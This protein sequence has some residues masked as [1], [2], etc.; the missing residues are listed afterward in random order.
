MCSVAVDP[1]RLTL[2]P[3]NAGA[4]FELAVFGGF[5]LHQSG[6][7]VDLPTRKLACLLTYL[8]CSGPTSQ[9][10]EKLATLLWGDSSEERARHNLRQAIAKLRQILGPGAILNEHD[11]LR[12]AAGTLSC[13][14]VAFDDLIRDGSPAALAEAVDLFKGGFLE[15]IVVREEAWNDWL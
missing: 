14:A 10:R 1:D 5:E 6:K 11:A 12:L 4:A 3:G 8:A 2:R 9:P 13:D 15:G 7:P